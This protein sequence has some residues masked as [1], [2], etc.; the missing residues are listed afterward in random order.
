M[1][2]EELSRINLYLFFSEPVYCMQGRQ[3][4]EYVR[5]YDSWMFSSMQ[6]INPWPQQPDS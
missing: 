2:Q 5:E 1:I 6:F 3:K 4:C